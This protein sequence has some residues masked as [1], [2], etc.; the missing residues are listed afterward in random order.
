V[1]S[2]RSSESQGSSKFG[3]ESALSESSMRSVG[4]LSSD[5]SIER[6][7]LDRIILRQYQSKML[8][9]DSLT[10]S[11]KMKLF[12]KWYLVALVGDLCIIFGTLFYSCSN[13]FRLAMSEMIIGIGSFLVWLS[14]VKYFEN[15]KNHYTILRTMGVATPQIFKVLIGFLPIMLGCCFLAMTIFYNYRDAFGGFNKA[16]YTLLTL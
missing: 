5:A 3:S 2:E 14:I 11:D 9:W 16:F 8:S 13:I 12:K 15:T 10:F 1:I 7:K 6:H 4:S